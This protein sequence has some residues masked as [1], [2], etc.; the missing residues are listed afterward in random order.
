MVVLAYSDA[1]IAQFSTS[2]SLMSWFTNELHANATAFD[3]ALELFNPMPDGISEFILINNWLLS[4]YFG[5]SMSWIIFL[6]IGL[7]RPF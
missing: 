4:R 3:T 6:I 5:G 7:P 1:S 2:S